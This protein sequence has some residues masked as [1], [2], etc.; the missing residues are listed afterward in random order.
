MTRGV[1]RA[2]WERLLDAPA[3]TGIKAWPG[4]RFWLRFKD[5]NK[6]RLRHP[7]EPLD[8]AIV[9]HQRA[10]HLVALVVSDSDS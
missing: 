8:G 6:A 7:G 10:D 3:R 4:T 5:L 9:E 1:E 2:A